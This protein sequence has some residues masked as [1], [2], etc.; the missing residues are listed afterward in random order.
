EART[1]AAAILQGMTAHYLLTSVFAVRAGHTA[2]VHAAAG[3]TGGILVQMAKA[4]G[5][6][7]LGTASTAKLD[8]VRG[9][10]AD[11]AIDYTTQD[12]QQ[13]V[14]RLTDGRGVDVVYDSV[15]RTTFDK[16]LESLAVR[17]MLALFGQS[18]GTVPAFKPSRLA[19]KAA[20][21]TRPSL[22]HYTAA[23]E[24][25]LWRARELFDDLA[26]GRVR[27]RVDRE[28]PLKDAAE[29][30]R[31]LEGRKTAGKVLLIP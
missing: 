19:K 31:L 14:M 30:H 8:I 6:R 28:L 7:V 9:D 2:L 17:G 12:F 1:A 3:G 5:A 23:R 29:A 21:L 26:S 27:L 11:A 18:S 13:E 15:G 16:S 4:R 20:F 22:A 10:G 25:L 24:E